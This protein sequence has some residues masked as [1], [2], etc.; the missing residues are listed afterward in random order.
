M[1]VF[2][3][4]VSVVDSNLLEVRMGG[5]YLFVLVGLVLVSLV[6]NPKP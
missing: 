5:R 3:R 1:S 4:F 2:V 6:I